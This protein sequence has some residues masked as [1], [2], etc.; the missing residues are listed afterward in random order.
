MNF[1]AK[2]LAPY[3]ESNKCDVIKLYSY[4]FTKTENRKLYRKPA[5]NLIFQAFDVFLN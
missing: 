3:N 1:L 5:K 2:I 4:V